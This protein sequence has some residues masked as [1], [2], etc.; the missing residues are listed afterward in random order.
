M[1]PPYQRF[2]GVWMPIPS[3]SRSLLAGSF[4]REI[5]LKGS[6]A[7]GWYMLPKTHDEYLI[8]TTAAPAVMRDCFNEADP[9]V[10]FPDYYGI[11]F[12]FNDALGCCAWGGIHQQ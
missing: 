11:L 8:G 5:Y 4:Q 3:G 6:T 10:Y 2:T 1:K 9:D 12:I 7:V